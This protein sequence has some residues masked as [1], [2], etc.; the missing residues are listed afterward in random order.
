MRSISLALLCG[1]YVSMTLFS[2]EMLTVALTRYS[3]KPVIYGPIEYSI[4]IAGAFLL[5]GYSQSTARQPPSKSPRFFW[6]SSI[7]FNL[8]IFLGAFYINRYSD[9]SVRMLSR[10]SDFHKT[11]YPVLQPDQILGALG[12][13]GRVFALVWMP[14]AALLSM[15]ALVI[16]FAIVDKWEQR[17]TNWTCHHLM[18]C[19]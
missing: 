14:V 2:A 18:E 8:L 6:M 10:L 9:L 4:L 3:C 15:V 7:V 12:G 17:L 16:A 19:F 11:F 5:R 13:L 1:A